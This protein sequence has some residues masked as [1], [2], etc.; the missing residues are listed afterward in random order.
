M[1]LE[2]LRINH[3]TPAGWGWGW[4]YLAALDAYD[5]ERYSSSPSP[6]VSMGAAG[7]PGPPPSQRRL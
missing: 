5:I 4:Q 6:D 3:L 1:E 7:R 2:E